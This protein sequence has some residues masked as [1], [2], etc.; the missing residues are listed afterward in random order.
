MKLQLY[1]I[2]DSEW[3]AGYS[4]ESVLEKYNLLNH[5]N[6]C[7]IDDIAELSSDDLG[8]ISFTD[9]EDT[10]D[11]LGSGKKHTLVDFLNDVEI[12]NNVFPCLVM[13]VEWC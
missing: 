11:F 1:N 6:Q 5:Q 8:L 2:R 3:W 12:H 13:M 4:K 9:F 7:F 10:T